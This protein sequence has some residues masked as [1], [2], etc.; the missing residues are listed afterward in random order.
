[1]R[2]EVGQ[3]AKKKKLDE[4]SADPISLSREKPI[5]RFLTFLLV[6]FSWV[7]VGFSS[8]IVFFFFL[9]AF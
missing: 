5:F 3:R 1:M 7:F 6:V 9:L 4:K 8:G 2:A